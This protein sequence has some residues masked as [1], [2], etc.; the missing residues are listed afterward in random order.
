MQFLLY[1]WWTAIVAI[2]NLNLFNA[3]STLEN[4]FFI[5][6][7]FATFSRFVFDLEQ[8]PIISTKPLFLMLNNTEL[9]YLAPKTIT[10]KR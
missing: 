6:C 5:L 3:S 2:S 9:A 4:V 7:K 10:F 1:I 8:I